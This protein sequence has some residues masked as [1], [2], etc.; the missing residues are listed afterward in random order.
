MH[1]EVEISKDRMAAALE[2]RGTALLIMAGSW[3]SRRRMERSC[4]PVVVW[5]SIATNFLR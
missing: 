2:R 3:G 5:S 1:G 4:V